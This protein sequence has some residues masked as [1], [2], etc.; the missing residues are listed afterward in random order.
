VHHP[1]KHVHGNEGNNVPVVQRDTISCGERR[2]C[3][4]V[5]L[6]EVFEK[7]AIK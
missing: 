3:Q 5:L 7:E 4:K 2:F 6:R 1:E